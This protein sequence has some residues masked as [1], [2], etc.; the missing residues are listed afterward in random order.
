MMMMKVM[1]KRM[2]RRRSIRDKVRLRLSCSSKWLKTGWGE[3][4]PPRSELLSG[5]V[6]RRSRW[7]ISAWSLELFTSW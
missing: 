4:H 5:L 3:Q 6:R 1:T 7:E 2:R